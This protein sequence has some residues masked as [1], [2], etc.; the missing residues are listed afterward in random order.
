MPSGFRKEDI[1]I[2]DKK[3]DIIALSEKVKLTGK[4]SLGPNGTPCF[5]QVTK[6]EK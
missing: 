1:K 6:I 2:H 3:G 4:M 5:I